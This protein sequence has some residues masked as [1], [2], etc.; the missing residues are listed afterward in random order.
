MS[1]SERAG[2]RGRTPYTRYLLASVGLMAIATANGVLRETTYGKRMSED[3]A[4]RLSFLPMVALFALYVNGLERRWPI[5]TWRGAFGIGA[6]WAAIAAGF[7]LAVGHYVDRK[8]W[9]RLLHEYNLAAG[10]V[11]GLVL[12][13]TAAMPGV[14]RL[15]H[16]GRLSG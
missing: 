5:A 11:G 2:R 9:S 13:A 7:E 6:S 14:V 8:P 16:R 15:S 4:H 10:R 3:A 12:L 1:A